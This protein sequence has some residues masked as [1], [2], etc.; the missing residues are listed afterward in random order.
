MHQNPKTLGWACSY[1]PLE[2]IAAA[3]M[4]PISSRAL[5]AMETVPDPR[6]FSPLPF[7]LMS[8]VCA[9]CAC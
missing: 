5:P 4:R 3:G 9:A 8:V 7:A 1:T 2:L 6:A